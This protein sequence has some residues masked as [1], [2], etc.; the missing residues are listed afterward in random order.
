MSTSSRI[1]SGPAEWTLS[2]D[3]VFTPDGLKPARLRISDGRLLAVETLVDDDLTPDGEGAAHPSAP[4][5]IS[6]EGKVVLP[7]FVDTHVHVNQPGRT[8]WEGFE[9]A[10]RA[11]AAGG[12]TTL[13]DM[14]LNSIPVTTSLQALE[15]KMASA[16]EHC[17]VDYGLWGGIVP[18]NAHEL[19]PM[20]D[21]G[22]P[23]FKCF[24]C[25]SGIDDFPNATESDLRVAMPILARR[26]IPLL[27]HAELIPPGTPEDDPRITSRHYAD[28]LASRPRAWENEAVRMMIRLCRETGCA[29]HIVHLASSDILPE[30]ALAKVEGLPISVET[31]PHYL[32]FD[33]ALIPDGATHFKCA[34]PIREAENREKLWQGL[35]EGII[36]FVVCDHSPCTPNLK[37][38]DSGDFLHAWGG[39]SSLQFAPSI[40]WTQAQ[41]RGFKLETVLQWLCSRTAR[42][43]GLT[44][45][46]SLAAG[47]DADF[48]LFD[49]NATWELTEER[50]HHRHRLTPYLGQS[51]HGMVH[52]TWLRGQKVFERGVP[53]WHS[54][55]PHG[56]LLLRSRT[57]HPVR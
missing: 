40:V 20:I 16:R 19:E 5:G 43:A 22:V 26:G 33:S 4:G 18:G 44:Q 56:Q 11:A 50:I 48:I 23:G 27:V 36:D 17:W 41:Q 24:L 25:H 49:P 14:P 37:L 31:C 39:I 2:A 38:M 13:I 54:P 6:T 8:E 7:G 3:Q 21:A 30:L 51:L 45:K 47:K 53:D 52:A 29:V 46:G 1:S 35:R 9:T 55:T 10:T 15:A 28:Y 42:F 12:I 34:P 32:T 57:S